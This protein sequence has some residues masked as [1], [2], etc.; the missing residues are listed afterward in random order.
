MIKLLTGKD[1][2]SVLTKQYHIS[3]LAQKGTPR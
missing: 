3:C 1:A 2:L